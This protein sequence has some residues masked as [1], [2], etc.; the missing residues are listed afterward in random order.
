MSYGRPFRTLLTGRITPTLRRL[1]DCGRQHNVSEYAQ[2]SCLFAS[3]DRYDQ[4]EDYMIEVTNNL[5][6]DEQLAAG[7]LMRSISWKSACENEHQ[8]ELRLILL[9]LGVMKAAF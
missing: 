6:G 1:L 9:R 5:S 4:K 7:T 8:L 3:P 2:D